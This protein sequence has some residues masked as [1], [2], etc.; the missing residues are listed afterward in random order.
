MRERSRA[1]PRACSASRLQRRVAVL[2]RRGRSSIDSAESCSRSPASAPGGAVDEH[3]L[4]HRRRRSSARAR[5]RRGARSSPDSL[6]RARASGRGSGCGARIAYDAARRGAA[7]A[8]ADRRARARASTRSSASMHS[9]QSCAR[10]RDGELLLP[11]EAQPRAA[12]SRARPRAC[13]IATVSSRLPE[14]TTSD[15]GGERAPTRGTP[16]A[17]SAASRVMTTS[18]REACRPCGFALDSRHF[19]TARF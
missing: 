11:A 7:S 16:R 14:S 10:L 19:E 13:A 6:R 17:A 5:G 4:V 2:L 12:R 3:L 9:T 18:E 1:R 8:A 15:L